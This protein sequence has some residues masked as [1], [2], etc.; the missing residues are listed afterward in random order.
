MELAEANKFV[1]WN[2]DDMY[3]YSRVLAGKMRADKFKPDAIVAIARGGYVPARNLCD[4]LGVTDL[5]SIKVD[6]WGITATRDQEGARL[7]YPFTAKLA[8]K[9]VL[10]VDD[11]ADTGESFRTA[12]PVLKALKPAS[13]KTASLF[14]LENSKFV[15]DYFASKREWAWMVFPWNFTEDMAVIVG[16]LFEEKRGAKT[17]NQVSAA[18]LEK[19]LH[20]PK[21]KLADALNELA[22]RGDLKE[23]VTDANEHAWTKGGEKVGG[24]KAGTGRAAK[25]PRPRSRRKHR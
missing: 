4:Q 11:I 25:L 23:T 15:P 6:H 21:N 8:G 7:R 5:L 3:E 12:L 13:I 1:L 14:L 24:K 17:L 16:K 10:L 22:A 19:N 9:K 2:W 20:V 18:L